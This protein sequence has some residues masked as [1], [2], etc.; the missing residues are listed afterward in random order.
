M[1]NLADYN[2]WDILGHL[3][4]DTLE[5]VYYALC[6]DRAVNI[7]ERERMAQYCFDNDMVP[8]FMLQDILGNEYDRI[9]QAMVDIG[10]IF[11]CRQLGSE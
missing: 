7:E 1:G 8:F 6:D 3:S 4:D 2:G 5:K 9:N 11:Y 10:A